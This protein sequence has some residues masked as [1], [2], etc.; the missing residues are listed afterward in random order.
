MGQA[1]RKDGHNHWMAQCPAHNDGRPSLSITA[2]EDGETLAY[3]FAGCEFTD[4]I[5]RAGVMRPREDALQRAAEQALREARERAEYVY[6]DDAGQPLIRV[7]RD[8]G[9]VIRQ[10]HWDGAGWQPGT[11]GVVPPLYRL[12]S[13]NAAVQSGTTIYVVEGEKDA[14]ALVA[15]G[16]CATTAI[17]GAKRKWEDAWTQSLRGADVVIVRDKDEPGHAHAQ[18]VYDALATEG[19]TASVVEAKA[20]K[21][22]FDHLSA[23]YGVSDFVSIQMALD[24][25]LS[26]VG[27]NLLDVRH[28]LTN[29][30]PAT[31]WA[32]DGIAARGS[33]TMLFGSGKTGKSFLAMEVVISALTG[34]GVV[35]G[36]WVA[37]ASWALMIDAE[38]GE[39]RTWRRLHALGV[40][41]TVAGTLHIADAVGVNLSAEKDM[42]ALRTLMDT[43]RTSGPGV[44]VFDSAT[45]L[46]NVGIDD[47]WRASVVRQFINDIRSLLRQQDVGLFIHHENGEGRMMGSRDWRNGSDNGVRLSKVIFEN[48]PSATEVAL[49]FCRD[50]EDGMTLARYRLR[51]VEPGDDARDGQLLILAPVEDADM[52]AQRSDSDNHFRN[53]AYVGVMMRGLTRA[54][55]DGVSVTS[56]ARWQDLN[57]YLRAEVAMAV[58][59]KELIDLPKSFAEMDGKH[60]STLKELALARWLDQPDEGSLL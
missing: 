11:N 6:T 24:E 26:D 16:V 34:G 17:G 46:R 25:M 31:E 28:M 35:A 21:D 36:R 33:L 18:K 38:N 59:R 60:I 49:D 4:I 1:V 56:P 20:G 42:T 39:I 14:D 48:E 27:I 41:D 58:T 55:E 29:A 9:K 44:I 52:P 50:G 57:R 30:P 53:E 43:I 3:C 13:I 15:A 12:T 51:R 47:E 7:T 10:W 45:A 32:W 37:P 5:E 2:G 54:H 22:A 23:G 19:I 8:P 40:P